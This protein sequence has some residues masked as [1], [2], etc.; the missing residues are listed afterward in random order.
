MEDLKSTHLW[1]RMDDRIKLYSG[2]EEFG[3]GVI[4]DPSWYALNGRFPPEKKPEL[5]PQ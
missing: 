2:C 1:E 3:R 5:C 4:V